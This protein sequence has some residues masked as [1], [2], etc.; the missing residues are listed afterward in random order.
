MKGKYVLKVPNGK[1]L[2]VFL[3]Y[4]GDRINKIKITGDFFIHPEETIDE[5]EREL[6]GIEFRSMEKKIDDFFEV[7][8]PKMFGITKESLKEAISM[9]RR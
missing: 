5:L 7:K 8:K 1:L 9:C 2:K 4:E 6:T 3:E